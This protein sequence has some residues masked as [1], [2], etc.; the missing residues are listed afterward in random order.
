MLNRESVNTTQ[1]SAIASFASLPLLCTVGFFLISISLG[2]AGAGQIV[3]P[4]YLVGSVTLGL[5][6][7]FREPLLFNGFV[8]NLWFL[9]P[10]V[11]RIV[12]WKSGF[13]DPSIILL[14]PYLVT[15]ISLLTFLKHFPSIHRRGALPFAIAS[16]SIGYSFL[17][18][19]VY[20]SPSEAVRGYLDWMSGI[21]FGFHI[22][23]NWR[24]YP[25]YR[26]NVQKVF[27]LGVFVMGT[28]GIF[29]YVYAPEWDL[30]W[31]LNTGLV[32]AGHLDS[33]E[34]RAWST[35][36]APLPFAS[37]MTAGLLVLLSQDG[38]L[39][40]P[41]TL[42]GF[43]SFLLSLARTAW[44]GFIVGL[45]SLTFVSSQKFQIRLLLIVI[46]L[47]L[48]LIPLTSMDAFS[49]AI[50]GR[51]GSLSSLSQDDSATTRAYFFDLQIGDALRSWLGYGIGGKVYDWGIF[52]LLFSLGWISSL[53]YVGSI[54]L[55]LVTLYQGKEHKA[56]PFIGVSRSIVLGTFSMIALATPFTAVTGVVL[57][58][59]LGMGLA[60]KKY[61]MSQYEPTSE[62]Q[63]TDVLS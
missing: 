30:L 37:T 58:S 39:A 62:N 5:F 43:L 6:L 49:E 11:R 16:L 51:L 19:F 24:D 25:A 26:R 47:V 63:A 60:G 22:F 13:T 56:D 32:S 59:F 18:A 21:A 28:Y 8:W 44:G 34:I 10:F 40:I 48:G 54:L 50:Y 36:N 42:V 15:M 52:S 7:F 12:D 14:A 9:S 46:I 33:T 23:A 4:A 3:N 57:W 17:I 41:A 31:R 45:I 53:F 55:S 35:M 20:K 29:Q 1:S 38:I 2:F 27:L 61:Y